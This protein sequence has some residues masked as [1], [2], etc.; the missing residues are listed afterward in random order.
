LKQ[1]KRN[2]QNSQEELK[3]QKASLESAKK[4]QSEFTRQQTEDARQLATLKA[5]TAE[6]DSALSNARKRQET[7]KQ[8][9]SSLSSNQVQLNELKSQLGQKIANIESLKTSLEKSEKALKDHSNEVN[10]YKSRLAEADKLVAEEKRNSAEKAKALSDAQNSAQETQQRKQQIESNLAELRKTVVERDRTITGLQRE[11]EQ[12][13]SLKGLVAER[14]S[15]IESLRA[16]IDRLSKMEV[17]L[18]EKNAQLEKARSE[19]AETSK[20]QTDQASKI[21]SLENALSKA[22]HQIA[23]Y[24]RRDNLPDQ[25]NENDESN[26][27]E[28][29][30]L[31]AQV[32]SL[33]NER[34]LGLERVKELSEI[35]KSIDEKDKIIRE[36][37][38]GLSDTKVSDRELELLRVKISRQDADLRNKKL[39]IDQLKRELTRLSPSSSKGQSEGL[40]LLGS[41][42]GGKKSTRSKSKKERAGDGA[43]VEDMD[44]NTLTVDVVSEKP[45]SKNTK[46]SS[47]SSKATA[48][49]TTAAKQRKSTNDTSVTKSADAAKSSTK[50]ATLYTAPAE[51]DDLKRIKGIGSVME[52]TLYALGVT[53]YRQIAEF[54]P[55]DIARV[56]EALDA[57]PGR[58][59][60][61]DWIGGAKR[62]YI[63]KYKKRS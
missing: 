33:I 55:A 26:P 24:V 22:N 41:R 39:T 40:E 60:R 25:L 11:H 32:Q 29:N 59:E 53:S 30:R 5:T 45:V 23:S 18:Q 63:E 17:S 36:L 20:L 9:E 54:T 3:K 51:K 15:D 19:L 38:N 13:K 50:S 46:S 14:Q 34:N 56:S 43:A 12:F 4:A 47:N 21:K 57:F 44:D 8:L 61:D 6:R 37:R 27:V 16:Q 2:L 31:N 62:H 48:K 58:I 35:A 42:K 1:L 10:Q 7:V 52:T 49:R 28:L